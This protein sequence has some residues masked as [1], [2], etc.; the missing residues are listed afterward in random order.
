MYIHGSIPYVFKRN[1]EGIAILVDWLCERHG[2]DDL[3]HYAKIQENLGLVQ[4]N[5]NLDI[6]MLPCTVARVPY[7]SD[8]VGN[9]MVH[10]AG[11]HRV[12]GGLRHPQN[13]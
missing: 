10:N 3:R 1:K 4:S 6:L 9:E 13:A 7:M 11:V 12:C 2:V 5:F 8:L